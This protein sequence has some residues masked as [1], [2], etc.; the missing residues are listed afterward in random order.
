[1]NNKSMGVTHHVLASNASIAACTALGSSET[2]SQAVANVQV[3][4]INR[5]V[6]TIPTI[7]SMRTV[8]IFFLLSQKLRTVLTK[9]RTPMIF[10]HLLMALASQWLMASQSL[11]VMKSLKTRT[12]IVMA[13]SH[14]RRVQQAFDGQLS[15]PDFLQNASLLV[16]MKIIVQISTTT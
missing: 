10:S 11:Q 13:Q 4:Q 16:N 5:I 8:V 14:L 7:A 1:M 12:P 6:M 2:A 9:K 15:G 3:Y